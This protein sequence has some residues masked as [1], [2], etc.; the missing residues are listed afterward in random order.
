M[1]VPGAD[2]AGACT[3]EDAEDT[4]PAVVDHHDAHLGR[5]VV[6]PQ[7][8]VVVEKSQIAADQGYRSG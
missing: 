1:Q 5:D 3:V 8:I 7:G 2:G 4:A 6:V